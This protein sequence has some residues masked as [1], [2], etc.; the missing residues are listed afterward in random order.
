MNPLLAYNKR[1]YKKIP[2]KIR[3]N[4]SGVGLTTLS[5]TGSTVQYLFLLILHTRGGFLSHDAIKEGRP[6]GSLL[7]PFM[8][9]PP[10]NY[11][12]I[13]TTDFSSRVVMN[14]LETHSLKSWYQSV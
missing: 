2:A 10:P 1:L 13:D 6:P 12:Q 3:L 4:P 7:P 11:T 14:G 8:P 5:I 9:G